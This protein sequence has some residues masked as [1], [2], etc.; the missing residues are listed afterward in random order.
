MKTGTPVRLK[1]PVIA[2]V[3]KERRINSTS[4]EVECLVEWNEDGQT[5]Q[6]WFNEDQLEE[7]A[8]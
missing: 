7:V 6:R 3:V 8:S 2:G 1:Q 4:D 5:V